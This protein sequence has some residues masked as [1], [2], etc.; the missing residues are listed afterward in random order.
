MKCRDAAQTEIFRGTG[1]A[2]AEN[3]QDY[4]SCDFGGEFTE[5]AARPIVT[6]QRRSFC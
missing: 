6:A 4:P 2:D 1:E 5:H 3:R